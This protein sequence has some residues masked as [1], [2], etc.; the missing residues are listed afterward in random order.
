MIKKTVGNVF[1]VKNI[2]TKIAETGYNVTFYRHKLPLPVAI[3]QH[4]DHAAEV[5]AQNTNA[6]LV[7]SK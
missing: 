6:K 2:N 1:T 4:S 3:I 7:L 5:L